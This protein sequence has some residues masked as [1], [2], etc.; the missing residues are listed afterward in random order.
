MDTS[1]IKNVGNRHRTK[2]VGTSFMMSDK[3]G[4]DKSNPYI[5]NNP[6]PNNRDD[7]RN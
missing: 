1:I 2:D 5:R 4:F 6:I 3:S 7:E